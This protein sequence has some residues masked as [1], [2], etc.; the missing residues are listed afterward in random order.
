MH[1]KDI[2]TAL[3]ILADILLNCNFPEDELKKEKDAQIMQITKEK[4]DIFTYGFK[5]LRKQFFDDHPYSRS[6]SGEI[7]TVSSIERDDLLQLKEKLLVGENTVISISGDF[8]KERSQEEDR[9]S[10]FLFPRR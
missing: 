8:N 6:S 1:S 9:T 5:N 4:D 2:D 3:D 7:S 10:I